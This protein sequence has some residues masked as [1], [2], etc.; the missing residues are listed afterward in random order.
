MKKNTSSY[1]RFNFYSSM[2]AGERGAYKTNLLYNKEL[3][4][5]L[6]FVTVKMKTNCIKM[7]T[8]P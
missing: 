4:N 2:K 6:P 1:K 3:Q 7:N 8:P 5:Q